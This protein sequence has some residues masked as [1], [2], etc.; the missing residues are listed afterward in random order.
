MKFTGTDRSFSCPTPFSVI[1]AVVVLSVHFTDSTS[2]HAAGLSTVYRERYTDDA[3][4]LEGK[5]ANCINI[6]I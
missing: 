3:V 4:V 2:H 5:G 1:V 6:T